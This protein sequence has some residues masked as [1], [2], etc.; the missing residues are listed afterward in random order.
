MTDDGFSRL[1]EKY[2]SS[3]LARLAGHV[4]RAAKRDDV[5]DIHQSRVAAR[6][7]RVAFKLFGPCFPKDEAAKWRRDLKRL[8]KGLGPARD[9][10]VQI[11]RSAF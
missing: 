11:R 5:E 9:A 6:R 4:K 10:D 7:L 8:L 3:E 1:A 2:V